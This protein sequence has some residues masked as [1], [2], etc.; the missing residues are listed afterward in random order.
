M[1]FNV[2]SRPSTSTT[3]P[4]SPIFLQASPANFTTS[5][6]VSFATVGM[7]LPTLGS[8]S[9]VFAMSETFWSM[10]RPLMRMSNLPSNLSNSSMAD[11]EAR[12]SG[13]RTAGSNSLPCCS[14]YVAARSVSAR[15][16]FPLDHVDAFETFALILSTVVP[17][18]VPLRP[19]R[20]MTQ[21]PSLG[22]FA[23]I[24]SATWLEVLPSTSTFSYV[25]GSLSFGSTPFSMACCTP[26]ANFAASSLSRAT[27]PS[28]S[29]LARSVKT[30]L[31]FKRSITPP[32]VLSFIAL[33]SS[34]VSAVRFVPKIAPQTA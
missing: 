8:F 5:P 28:N 13:V 27:M 12:F 14:Q 7:F 33:R 3:V 21:P 23:K 29:F 18:P 34:T 30:G 9:R 24:S 19:T 25:G 32:D 20:I 22:S 11:Q 1:K 6:C 10:P 17:F 4:S 26:A 31:P 16:Q 2:C 15:K